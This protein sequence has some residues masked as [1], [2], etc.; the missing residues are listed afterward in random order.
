MKVRQGVDV[1]IYVKCKTQQKI[2]RTSKNL[3]RQLD[4][5]S[6]NIKID[7]TLEN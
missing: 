3:A 5:K 7:I 1:I 4:I 6:D 2:I